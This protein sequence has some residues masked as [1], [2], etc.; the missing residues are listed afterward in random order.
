MNKPVSL[1]IVEKIVRVLLLAVFILNTM[2]PLPAMLTWQPEKVAETPA[3]ASEKEQ[4]EQPLESDD[5]VSAFVKQLSSEKPDAV[6]VHVQHLYVWRRVD[7]LARAGVPTIIFA[8]IGMAFTPHVREISR[9]PG[10][11]VISSLETGAI[12]QA[13]R[14]IRAKHQLEQM[15]AQVI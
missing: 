15:L 10:V 3:A 4:E 7:T 13:L 5:A 12:E 11:H 2:V 14:M 8:P 6:L 9:R 1:S